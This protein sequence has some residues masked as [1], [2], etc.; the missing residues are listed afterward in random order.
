MNLEQ[1]QSRYGD[2]RVLV[3][4]ADEAGHLETGI[5]GLAEH[6]YGRLTAASRFIP[7]WQ[8]EYNPAWRQLIPYIVVRQNGRFLLTR[9]R[10]TQGEVRLHS[11]HSLGVGGHINP[12]DQGQGDPI[13]AG[14]LRELNEEL[15]LYDWHPEGVMPSGVINDLS[16]EVSRDH[17]G[18]F[19]VLDVPSQVPVKVREQ[20]KMTADWRALA[21]LSDIRPAMES[22][23]QL[24]LDWLLRK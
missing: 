17:L 2:E 8:A 16:N 18:I 19:Y 24:V 15:Q 1:L 20:D 13:A 10:A 21:D 7:R 6:E 23:S 5:A 14:M 9:R 22:W 12:C 4:P 3:M 11:L